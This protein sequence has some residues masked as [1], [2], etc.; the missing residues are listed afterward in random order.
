MI[1][2]YLGKSLVKIQVGDLVIAI[3]PRDKDDTGKTV[4]FGADIVLISSSDSDHSSIESVTYGSKIPFVIDTPGEFEVAGAYITGLHTDTIEVGKSKLFPTGKKFNTSFCILLEGITVCHLGSQEDDV[5]SG[6]II[7]KMGEIDVL[8]LPIGGE[9]ILSPEK[10]YKLAKKLD[11][12]IIIPISYGGSDPKKGAL[13]EFLKEMG[14]E[15][16]SPQEK[17]VLKKKDLEGKEEEV[18]V[19]TQ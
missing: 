13:S 17:L 14:A 16:I 8:S 4:K 7:E 12:K 11:P 1:I 15:K 10:A 9:G 3:N 2:S 5:I 19:L 18:I 6:D